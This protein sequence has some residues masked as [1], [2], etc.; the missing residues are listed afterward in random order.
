[1]PVLRA[2]ALAVEPGAAKVPG[3][4]HSAWG[5]SWRLAE[6]GRQSGSGR[7]GLRALSVL[8]QQHD[9]RAAASFELGA[10]CRQRKLRPGDRD[11]PAGNGGNGN[12]AG[13]GS[14]G[15]SPGGGGG[16]GT[17]SGGSSGNGKVVVTT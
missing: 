1:V 2:V 4:R 10:Q 14:N 7:W 9:V 3:R 15:T 17:T 12:G 5:R 6:R 16:S 8:V 11:D 13:A